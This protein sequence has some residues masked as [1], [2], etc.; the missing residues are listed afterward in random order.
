MFEGHREAISIAT[1]RNSTNIYREITA[2]EKEK[3]LRK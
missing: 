2:E 1:A 3:Q